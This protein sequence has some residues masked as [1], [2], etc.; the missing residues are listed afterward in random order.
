MNKYSYLTLLLTDMCVIAQFICSINSQFIVIYLI[1]INELYCAISRMI[2]ER[3]AS[4]FRHV[5]VGKMNRLR[6]D[7]FGFRS[8]QMKTVGK[9]TSQRV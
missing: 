1:A 9:L 2:Y 6:Y 3:T 4:L 8:M 7:I 5:F